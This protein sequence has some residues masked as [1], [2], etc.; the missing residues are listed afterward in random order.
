MADF[1][2]VDIND[3][4][5]LLMAAINKINTTFHYKIQALQD[6]VTDKI[7]GLNRKIRK[8]ESTHNELEARVEGLESVV[9]KMTDI[10]Q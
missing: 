9:P 1:Q 3:K 7:D 2:V 4:L 6:H 5:N 8:M 10:A